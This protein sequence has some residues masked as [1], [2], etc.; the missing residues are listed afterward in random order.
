MAD[1]L[2]TLS[3]L[4]AFLHANV[5]AMRAGCTDGMWWVFLERVSLTGVTYAFYQGSGDT[6]FAA[7]HAAAEEFKR[8][9]GS[10]T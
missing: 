2:H 3:D 8:A 9:R 6:L 4:Q 7:F 10:K 1:E 5:L